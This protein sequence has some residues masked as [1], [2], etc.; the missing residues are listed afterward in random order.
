MPVG[1]SRNRPFF[2]LR[3][4][5]LRHV[6]TKNG[7]MPFSAQEKVASISPLNKNSNHC[8]ILNNTV[9][10]CHIQRYHP[11]SVCCAKIVCLM[12]SVFFSVIF[13]RYHDVFF[14]NCCTRLHIGITSITISFPREPCFLLASIDQENNVVLLCDATFID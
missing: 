3:Y 6:E 2:L 7:I 12:S 8:D 14:F 11:G 13:D 4:R 9:M 10:L 5:H 1:K